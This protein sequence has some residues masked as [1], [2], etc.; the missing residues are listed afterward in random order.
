MALFSLPVKELKGSVNLQGIGRR[1]Q[2][3]EAAGE[4]KVFYWR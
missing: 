1:Q 3:T 4:E 2:Q